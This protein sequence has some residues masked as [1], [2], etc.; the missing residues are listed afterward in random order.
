MAQHVPTSGSSCST[1]KNRSGSDP[2]PHN[3]RVSRIF[4]TKLLFFKLIKEVIIDF[5]SCLK[6]NHGVEAGSGINGAIELLPFQPGRYSPAYQKKK[7]K[8]FMG[9]VMSVNFKETKRKQEQNL[10]R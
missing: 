3:D 8:W 6:E 4:N 7:K 10:Q 9:L 5:T 1:S 2:F